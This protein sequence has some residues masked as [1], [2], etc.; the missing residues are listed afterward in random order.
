LEISISVTIINHFKKDL[1]LEGACSR[2]QLL[3]SAVIQ[4]FDLAFWVIPFQ[5]STG[6]MPKC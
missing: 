3:W 1:K 6:G 2:Q 4:T 5:M